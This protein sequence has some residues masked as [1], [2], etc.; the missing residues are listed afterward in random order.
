M[1][2]PMFKSLAFIIVTLSFCSEALTPVKFS[3]G[4]FDANQTRSILDVWRHD[5]QDGY[6]SESFDYVFR[7]FNCFEKIKTVDCSLDYL[8]F[9]A[10]TINV[11]ESG[12]E[13]EEPE[14]PYV[15]LEKKVEF[16]DGWL[17]SRTSKK[18]KGYYGAQCKLSFDTKVFTPKTVFTQKGYIQ[19]DFR[20]AM[21]DCLGRTDKYLWK[22]LS[23]AKK[24]M[25]K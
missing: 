19:E 18:G 4:I 12:K 11:D 10:K 3:E 1:G 8:L 7:Q 15:K 25:K 6:G 17:E 9:I 23:D 16:K 13:T 5:D 21:N 2:G 20:Q 14:F 24:A 22:I